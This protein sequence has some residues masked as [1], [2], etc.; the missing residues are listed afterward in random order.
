MCFF[1][2]TFPP[3]NNAFAV[4]SSARCLLDLQGEMRHVDAFDMSLTASNCSA[5][6]SFEPECYESLESSY[7]EK[8]YR[9]LNKV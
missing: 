6:L 9:T 5:G 3:V 8:H 7:L 2:R 1:F 4:S